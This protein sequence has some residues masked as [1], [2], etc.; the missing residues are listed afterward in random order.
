M[1]A[2]RHTHPGTNFKSLKFA[3][4]NILPASEKGFSL[5]LQDFNYK[6]KNEHN[7]KY[8]LQICEYFLIA[9]VKEEIKREYL[10]SKKHC[11]KMKSVLVLKYF[12]SNQMDTKNQTKQP[13]WKWNKPKTKAKPEQR[14]WSR[15]Q[16]PLGLSP[17]PGLTRRPMP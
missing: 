12:E 2:H 5:V 1:Y 9:S 15:R 6:P 13:A 17:G 7:K 11:K 3:N 8:N 10:E 4:G 16:V 14:C